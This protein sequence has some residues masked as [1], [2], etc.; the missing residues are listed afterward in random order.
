MLAGID[1]RRLLEGN[2]DL[3]AALDPTKI[4]SA[5]PLQ[6][7]IVYTRDRMG[8]AHAKL[9]VATGDA[10]R[11]SG[12]TRVER[13]KQFEASTALDADY[14]Y[15]RQR[16]SNEIL[17]PPREARVSAK[18]LEARQALFLEFFKLNPTD[19]NRQTP[20]RK[21]VVAQ[22]IVD[23]A[24]KGP[25]CV[26]LGA[27]AEPLRTRLGPVT[28]ELASANKEVEREQR[29]DREEFQKLE[30]AR[31]DFDK[32]QATHIDQIETALGDEGRLEELGR[33]VRSRDPAYR[34]RQL[35]GRPIKE[36]EGVADVVAA[37]GV[38]TDA[39]EP[40]VSVP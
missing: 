40:A 4:T 21:V 10:E 29:E 32:R 12:E 5:Q 38:T 1:I 2:H 3:A 18:D 31:T 6:D 27:E 34:A 23:A 19:F 14:R 33:Y 9:L 35:A 11:E 39:I 15:V 24:G 13:L 26:A 16:A 37:L 30:Q 22:A 17:N 7:A 8:A 25:L 20:E 36:E 28:T